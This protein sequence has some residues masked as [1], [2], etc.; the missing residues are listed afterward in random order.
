MKTVVLNDK[1]IQL[2]AESP[3]DIKFLANANKQQLLTVKTSSRA[4]DGPYDI[5]LLEVKQNV[6]K[7]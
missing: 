6:E 5:V 2:E 7:K 1:T 4:G 3:L